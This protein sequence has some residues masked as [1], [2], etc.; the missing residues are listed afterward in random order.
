MKK[1]IIVVAGIFK[2]E[3]KEILCALCSP[4]MNSPNLWGFP[5]GKIPNNETKKESIKFNYSL[6]FFVNL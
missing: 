2:N 6:A 3:S 5:G 1:R 4:V